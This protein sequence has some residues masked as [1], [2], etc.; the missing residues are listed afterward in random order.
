MD[1]AMVRT[2]LIEV[3][4][5]LARNEQEHEVL[6]SLLKGYEGWLRLRGLEQLSFAVVPTRPSSRVK[7][8]ISLRA[9]VLTVLKRARGEALHTKEILL[10]ARALGAVTEAK[11][12]EGVVDLMARNWSKTEPVKKMGRPRT[13]AWVGP[14]NGDG[15]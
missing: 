3:Q 6:T 2:Q 5:A 11:R 12:P 14:M 15:A 4:R 8:S 10:R 7:G 13:W 1:D 9:A